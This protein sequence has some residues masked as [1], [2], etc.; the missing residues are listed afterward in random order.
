MGNPPIRNDELKLISKFG[1][2]YAHP[3][4]MTALF[5][6]DNTTL[7]FWS[8]LDRPAPRWHASRHATPTILADLSAP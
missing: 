8:D 1:L 6:D 4:K 3:E 7:M 2:R 5:Y